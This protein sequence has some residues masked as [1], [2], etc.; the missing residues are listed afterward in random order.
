MHK[1]K[2]YANRKL[3]DTTDKRYISLDQLSELIKT[4]E[5]VVIVDN[6]SGEDITSTIVSQLLARDKKE[7]ETEVPTSILI[8]LLRKGSG[9]VVDYAR[10]YA[11]FFQ[12]AMTMAE[13][14]I[15]RLVARLVKDKELS[16][17]EGWR[18]K[19]E[20]TGYTENLKNWIG[21]RIDQRLKDVLRV[22]NL[23]TKDQVHDLTKKIDALAEK[24]E[25]LEKTKEKN[26]NTPH[27]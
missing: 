21:E 16:E 26:T 25:R 4:G 13:D 2:K 3:Y 15:D 23:V 1:I 19:K 18:L 14:E 11:G 20:I 10:K 24:L 7:D 9:T 17:K 12:N 6:R 8:Q 5:E 27:E 22:T